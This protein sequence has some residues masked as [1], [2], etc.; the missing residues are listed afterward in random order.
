MLT[1][2]VHYLYLEQQLKQRWVPHRE[3]G[4]NFIRELK[5]LKVGIVGY[6]NIGTFPLAPSQLIHMSS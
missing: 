6:G 2:K 4:G 1:H 5:T 3:L